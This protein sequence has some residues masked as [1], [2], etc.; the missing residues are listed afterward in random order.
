MSSKPNKWLITLAL[1]ALVAPTALQTI[2]SA[3]S[4]ASNGAAL[5]SLPFKDINN[6]A[7]E[8]KTNI[9]RAIEAGLLHG[10]PSGSY[11]PTELLTRQEMAVLLTQALQLSISK[12]ASSSFSDV[13]PKS[14]SSPYIEAVHRAGLMNGD[15]GSKFRPKAAVTREEA[16][17][18]LMRAAGLPITAD[19]TESAKLTDWNRVSP[20]ARPYVNTALQSG[21]MKT[22]QSGFKPKSSVQRQDIAQYMMSTFFPKDH[23]VQLQKVEDGKAWINGI[24]Y[25]LSDSVKGILQTSNQEILKGADIQFVASQRTIESITKLVIHAS[26]QAPIGQASEFS[27]NLVLD[28]HNSSIDGDLTIDGDYISVMN[29]NVKNSF[30]VTSSL[31]HDF[32]ASKFTV[33]GK[34]YI[35]GGDQNTVLFN[36]S[37]LQ[38][39]EVSKQ[40]VHVVI[41]GNSTVDQMSLISNATIENDSSSTIQQLNVLTGAKQV[42][43]QGIIKQLSVNS[44]QPVALTGQASINT[45][46]VNSSSPVSLEV[47]GTIS[48]LQVNN[49]AANISVSSSSQVTNTSFAVGV[50][51]STVSG[52]TG[53]TTTSSGSSRSTVVTNTAPKLVTK[54]DDQA[55]T[56]G[57]SELQ[58]DLLGH[59]TDE[60]QSELKYTAVSSSTKISTVRVEGT[61]LFI[62]AVGKGTATITI[63]ADDQAGKKAGTNFKVRVNESPVSLSIPDQNEQLGSGDVTL[64]LGSFFT[65]SENDPMTYEVAI[66]DPSIATFTLTGDQLVLTPAA[67]GHVQV[68]VK[69]SDGRGGSASQS[70]QLVVTAV[71]NQNPVV[72]QKPGN[73]TLTVGDADYILDLSPV[74]LDSDSNPLTISA[75]SSDLSIATVSVNG[76]Q[77]TVHAVSSGTANI[78]LKATNGLGGEVKTDFDITVNEPP[79]SLRIPDQTK[80]I[81]SDDIQ[82]SLND[83]FTDHEKDSLSYS[84]DISDSSVA[85]AVLNGDTLTITPLKIGST[86]VSVK[87]SDGHG[88]S[89]SQS[90]QMEVTAVSNQNP[91]IDQKPGNQ[92]LNLGDVD[93]IL[94]LS[95]VFHDPD[96]DPVDVLAESSDSS[97]AVVSVNGYIATVHAVSSGTATIQLKAN[98]GRG[99]EVTTDF[100]VT[101]NESPTS[102]GIP[103]QMKE[104]NTGDIQLSLNDFFSNPDSDVLTYD[105]HS[106]S[107]PTVVTAAVYGDMLTLTPLTIGSTSVSIKATDSWGGEVIETFKT[108]VT[109]GTPQNQY[110]VETKPAD[111][112]LTVGG[113][114]YSLDLGSVFTDPDGDT[115]TFKATSSDPSVASAEITGAQLEIQALSA[116]TTIIEIK[117]MDGRGGETS[118]TFQVSVQSSG[119][120]NPSSNQPP[121]VDVTIYE[122]VLTAGVTNARSYDLSQLFSDA[123][124]DALTFTSTVESTGMVNAEVNGSTLTLTPGDQAGSTK[125]TITANDGHGGTATYNFQVTNAPLATNGIVQIRTKQGVKDPITYDMSTV[126][127]GETSFKIYSGTADSTFTGPIPLNGTVWTWN[128]DI[129]QYFWVIGANG[130][131][132]IF[133]VTSNPQGPEDLYFSQYLSL[134]KTRTAIELFYN[135]VGDTS[136]PIENAGYSLEIHQYNLATNTPKVWSQPINSFWKGMPYIYIDSIF[137]DFFDIVPATY[138]NDELML[139][140]TNTNVTTG[141]VLKKNGVTI[142]VLGDPNGKTQFMPNNGTIIR[143]SGIKSGSSSYNLPG[144]WNSYPTGTLQYFSHHT[145]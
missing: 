44:D 101:V 97:V 24:E 91:V 136:K 64:S 22:D 117:A 126:F 119:S 55:V 45:L 7:S 15:D 90:F 103:D 57:D 80:Q 144:E 23:V 41:Q 76:N 127:P 50:S 17:V 112:S 106:I 36:T 92:T 48:N 66:D 86:S 33:Q 81:N 18:L 19:A 123:D 21:S 135:P 140:E 111:Q 113:A 107:D 70:F 20:W 128:G 120:S 49:S 83:F 77:A 9:L 71:P 75:E 145:P 14:W 53:V 37:E 121:Q 5:A 132:A 100:D 29:L 79:V 60:E 59:F 67:V 84:I 54:Y 43:L 56:V 42:E 105:V 102:T 30:T 2:A 34:T 4:G 32:Y 69:A 16:A 104:I 125:V 39:V 3:A 46:A 133:Q 52:V 27:G 114:V 130:S 62:K 139:L 98:D 40:D 63:A 122:Q 12:A 38:D 13:E 10:D 28:G 94:D 109:A 108:T 141:Y 58:I 96:G 115:L 35:Q 82:L 78:Q 73:Q 131:A 47:A 89:T 1:A 93:Y 95:S 6:I 65:D 31:E 124:G 137:Y 8:Q 110:P 143:K 74:F 142:D 25:K 85:T 138:Y 68:T 72:N 51:S 26:G 116:G 61:N 11:R 129:F 134:D 88:G 87:A 99:G 118:T